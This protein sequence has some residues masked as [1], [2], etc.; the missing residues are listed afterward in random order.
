MRDTYAQ[1]SSRSVTKFDEVV[2]TNTSSLVGPTDLPTTIDPV[3]WLL[4]KKRIFFV[5]PRTK[6]KLNTRQPTLGKDTSLAPMRETTNNE[7]GI[8]N[9]LTAAA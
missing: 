8:T 5:C 6:S 3:D 7:R 1:F 9:T 2:S 4:A